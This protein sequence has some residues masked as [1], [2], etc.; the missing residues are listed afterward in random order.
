MKEPMRPHMGSY[1]FLR[2]PRSGWLTAACLLINAGCSTTKQAVSLSD[3]SL[4]ET[5]A[6]AGTDAS[7]Q[8]VSYQAS[9]DP[10]D[11]VVTKDT[12]IP[13]SLM[14]ADLIRLTEERNPRLAQVAWAVET[15]RG[16]AYQ[17]G[18]YPNPVL[19]ASGDELS[20]RFG[21]GGIWS[22]PVVSQ[23]I[24][25]ANKL[26]LERTIAL[27]EV[28]RTGMT[29]IAERYRLLTEVRREYWNVIALERRETIL[30]ELVTLAEA[31]VKAI[32][33]LQNVGEAARLDAVQLEVDLERFRAERDAVSR[34]RPSA[35]VKLAASVGEPSIASATIMGTL[36]LPIP[37]YD[38]H[39]AS[40]YMA[41]IHPNIRSAQIGVERARAVLERARVE[42]YPNVTMAAGYTRQNQ[43]FSHD[44]T[45]TASVPVPLWNRNQGNI[46]AE[47]AAL[48]EAINEVGRVRNELTSQLASA[49]QSYAAE[50]ARAEKY[51]THIIPK[52]TESYELAMKGRAGG[53]L[54]SLKVL[55]AQRALAE[56]KLELLTAQTAVWQAAAEIAG[57]LLEDDWPPAPK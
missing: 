2:V 48:G 8:A 23:E 21:Q 15:A 26:G 9:V 36:D 1:R 4:V 41:G 47:R 40:Q 52:A 16:R 20:D 17:A 51:R 29:T 54:E 25:T 3:I 10:T 19:S 22:A 18:L 50:K 30:N 31:S 14:L 43:N 53:Q 27:K 57:L 49:Y 45:L 35:L 55:Q 33:K 42:P 6:A 11:S 44:W 46:H 5:A 24:V 37:S 34:M 32:E 7:I 56:S 28:D 13:Q 38:L 12:A 39:R